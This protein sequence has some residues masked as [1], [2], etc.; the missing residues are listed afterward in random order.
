[1]LLKLSF[2]LC[3]GLKGKIKSSVGT[4]VILF[5]KNL[6]WSPCARKWILWDGVNYM[7]IT[8]YKYLFLSG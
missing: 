1:M 5:L 2:E 8:A 6:F 3:T 4:A 7:Y